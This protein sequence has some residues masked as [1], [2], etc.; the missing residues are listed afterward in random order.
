MNSSDLMKNNIMWIVL[1]SAFFYIV[2]ILYSD[3]SEIS[4]HF[5]HVKVEFVFLVF[6]I[7][8]VSHVI[9]SIRQ[10]EFLSSLDEKISFKQNLVIYL[11]GMSMIS[12]PG[13]VGMFIKSHYLKRQFQIN[14]NKSFAVIFLERYHDLL[15]AT[16]IIVFSL[17]LA[18]SWISATLVI[19]S[20]L[21]L[22]GVYL[23]ITNL[24]VFS[25]IHKKLSMIKFLEKKLS[26]IG[27]TESLFILTR[28]KAMTK[29]WFTS[30]VG[31]SLDS[32]AVY[33]GFLAFNVDLGYLLTS[34]IYFTSLGYGVLSLMPGGIGVTEGI[35]DY[36]LVKQGLHLSIASSLV[37]F[38][39][40][41]TMWFATI[42]GVVFTRFALKQKVSVS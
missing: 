13:G 38:A 34:Q 39:R 41:T 9:K 16:S 4:E 11:A 33:I 32:L 24:G 27:P 3:A 8:I 10:K 17:V 25:F 20:C 26:G 5:L 1:G 28:P 23:A 40:L 29:G 42:I 30:M 2:F 15:A 6:L 22:V 36:L 31:W 14:N 21:L 18:F 37:V 35:A 12:T 7:G 19:I